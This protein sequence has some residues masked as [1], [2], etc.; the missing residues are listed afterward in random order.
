MKI[1]RVYFSGQWD[2]GMEFDT[3]DQKKAEHVYSELCLEHFIT[4]KHL[5][6]LGFSYA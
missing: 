3:T 1:T 6:S 4:H 2:H 5:E